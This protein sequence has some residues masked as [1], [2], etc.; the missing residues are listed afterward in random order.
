[1]QCVCPEGKTDSLIVEGDVGVG[2]LW[3]SRCLCHLE[4]EDAPIS[5][6]LLSA[7]LSWGM[8]YGVWIDWEKDEPRLDRLDVEQEFNEKGVL[9]TEQLKQEIGEMYTI[10]YVPSDI[11]KMYGLEKQ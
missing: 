9:L 3:C 11:M 5:E 2:P 6:E 4:A 7:L 10:V 8:V 1:M